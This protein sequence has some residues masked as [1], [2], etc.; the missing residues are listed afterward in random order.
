MDITVSTIRDLCTDA[1]FERGEAYLD[2][3]R[4]SQLSRFDDTVTGV[5][6]GSRAYDLEIEY[7]ASPPS[8]HCSCP[9]DGP[10]A[11]KHVVAVL[12]RVIETAPPDESEQVDE[13]LA[14]CSAET[15]RAF[16]RW[17]FASDPSLRDRF[18]AH[19]GADTGSSAETIKTRV[20]RLFNDHTQ[21]YDLV[22]EP[23]DFSE[24][25]DLAAKHET[26]GNH[27]G[28]I[29]IYRGLIEGVD[30]NIE[31]VDGAYDHF[32]SVFQ[33]ALDGYVD[34]VVAAELASDT[35]KKHRQFLDRK[36]VEGT[37]FH[38]DRFRIAADE[39]EARLD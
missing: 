13:L 29:P 21:E 22:F 2:E 37:D 38:R 7:T 31:L 19:V 3:G 25:F 10:G 32:A 17:E 24:L 9:Y 12:L 15:L 26:N 30:D 4:I 5:V 18:R 35:L 14:D 11:C 27:E 16:L 1:V 39:L 6:V 36:T 28:A 34:C 8:Y 23:I 20:D 33:D